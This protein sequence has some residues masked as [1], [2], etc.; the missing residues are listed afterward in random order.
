MKKVFKFLIVLIVW[1]I[2][3]ACTTRCVLFSPQTHLMRSSVLRLSL[4]FLIMS[5][6]ICFIVINREFARWKVRNTAIERRDLIRNPVPLMPEF[7]RSVRLLGRR[8]TTQQFIDTIIKKY[9]THLLI[10]ATLGGKRGFKGFKYRHLAITLNTKAQYITINNAYTLKID[11]FLI[12]LMITNYRKCMQQGRTLTKEQKTKGHM[13]ILWNCNTTLHRI[14]HLPVCNNVRTT[15]WSSLGSSC[16]PGCSSKQQNCSCRPTSCKCRTQQTRYVEIVKAIY[17]NFS[18]M[19][20]W[21]LAQDQLHTDRREVSL[22]PEH[23]FNL[24]SLNSHESH[25][26]NILCSYQTPSPLVGTFD[27]WNG[28]TCKLRPHH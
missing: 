22:Y 20:G 16:S 28:Q 13:I 3:P 8:P 26:R 9:G 14:S 2:R 10:S 11:S 4:L 18:V 5:L 1:Q 15:N 27:K 12:K 17:V 21:R 19:Q 7:Q 23:V 6:Y 24:V 25:D